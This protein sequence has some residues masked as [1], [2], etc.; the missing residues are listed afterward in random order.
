[1]H[2]PSRK[3]TYPISPLILNRWSSRAFSG[4]L[5]THEELMAVFEAARWAPSSSNNQPWR[6][7]YA[8]KDT[9]FWKTFFDLLV[10]ENQ[11][12][13]QRASVLILVISKRLLASGKSSRTHSFDAGASWENL[14]LQATALNLVA[15]AMKGF[16]YEK[17][18]LSLAVPSTYTIEAMIALGRKG[19]DTLLTPRE[20]ERE[21]PSGRKELSEII[22]EGSFFEKYER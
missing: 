18:R 20:R 11:S 16:D 7:I 14:A 6:F 22:F 5:V 2:V 8:C 10:P 9:P 13:V 4:E 17:A 21:K 1:M 12:W 3:P 15:H 19:S